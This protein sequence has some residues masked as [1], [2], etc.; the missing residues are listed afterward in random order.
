MFETN[1]W[2]AW[3]PVRVGAEWCWLS[4]VLRTRWVYIPEPGVMLP[5]RWWYRDLSMQLA[6]NGG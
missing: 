2:F 3:Y 6:T 5:T 1:T 4:R